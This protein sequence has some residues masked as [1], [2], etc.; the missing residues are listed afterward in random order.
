MSNEHSSLAHVYSE[1][2]I[3]R[4]P[5]STKASPPKIKSKIEI[6]ILRTKLQRQEKMFLALTGDTVKEK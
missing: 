1:N 4:Q 6:K 3:E 5:R 2:C